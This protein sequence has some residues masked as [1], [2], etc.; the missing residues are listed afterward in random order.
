MMKIPK[1]FELIGEVGVDS[2]QLMVCDPCYI[3]SE[4]GKSEEMIA[5]LFQHVD[6]C[7]FYCTLHGTSP[8][9]DARPFHN[10]EDEILPHGKTMNQMI[11]A[12]EAREVRT[13]PSGEFSYVGCCAA[14]LDEAAV[15]QLNFRAGH[16]GAGVV[17]SS[18]YGDGCYPVI[19]RRNSDG[20]VVEVRILMD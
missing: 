4:W 14:T 20:R 10:F 12:G 19:A 1:N 11:Q 5:P 13:K 8:D 7:T 16:T 15:G 6:G 3:G 17:F 18:G 9:P 2:G